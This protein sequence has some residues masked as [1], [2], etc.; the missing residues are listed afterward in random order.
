MTVPH[1]NLPRYWVA[2]VSAN[3]VAVGVAE[4]FCQACHG[5]AAPL[6]RMKQGDYLLL[7]PKMIMEFCN[8]AVLIRRG[9]CS[10]S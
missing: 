7:Q 5:K 8:Y 6:K 9:S 4:G 1:Q 3:H 10:I 2:V